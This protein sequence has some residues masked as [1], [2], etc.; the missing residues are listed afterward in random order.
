VAS[1]GFGWV[2]SHLL[3][4]NRLSA[5]VAGGV[6]LFLAAILVWRVRDPS[7]A[8]VMAPQNQAVA[9]GSGAVA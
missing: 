8:P 7:E 6:F 9:S 1:L 4:N 3:D 2:M 5:V